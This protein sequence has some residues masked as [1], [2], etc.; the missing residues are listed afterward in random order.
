MIRALLPDATSGA[1]T[2]RTLLD[3]D[4]DEEVSFT[5]FVNGVKDAIAASNNTHD[6]PHVAISGA[7]RVLKILTDYVSSR[8]VSLAQAFDEFCAHRIPHPQRTHSDAQAV[9]NLSNAELKHMAHHL[10]QMDADGGHSRSPSP[11]CTRLSMCP[12][13]S[14]SSRILEAATRRRARDERR[15]NVHH[16]P[17]R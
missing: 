4:S 8:G 9:P 13:L 12:G 1:M 7:R 2:I 16:Q 5:E 10:R 3:I 14:G 11:R 6:A 17:S 15:G